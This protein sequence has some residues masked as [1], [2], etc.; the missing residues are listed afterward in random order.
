MPH[1]LERTLV[2]LKPDAIQ[3]ALV[4]SIIS[5]FEQKG[6]K[7]VAMKMMF[8][9]T[10]ILDKHYEHHKG[11]P[12]FKDLKKFMS[13]SP[14][15]VMVWQGLETIAAVRK[16]AGITKSR[17]AEM[18]SIRGDF[19]MSM[20]LNLIHASDSVESAKKEIKTFFSDERELHD[21]DRHI[22]SLVYSDDEILPGA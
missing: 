5:R 15:V 4:G 17:E 18:G 8:L 20:Q 7:L 12:F 9:D 16:L 3:R 22:A 11:K 2:I 13:S 10:E 1:G 19:G 21:W 14:C 6:L